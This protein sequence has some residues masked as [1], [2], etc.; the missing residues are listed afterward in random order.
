MMDY[1]SVSEAM[2]RGGLRLVLS[3]GMPAPWSEAAKAIFDV[4]NLVYLPVEQ[5]V[6]APDG[7]LKQWTGQ[8]SAPTAMYEAERPRTRWDEIL[9]LAERLAPEPSLVPLNEY[10]RA[11][12]F[13]MTNAI[14]GE[15]GLGWN[16][17]LIVMRDRIRN[18]EGQPQQQSVVTKEQ[19]LRLRSRYDD[20]QCSNGK[21]AKRVTAV[22]T[23]LAEQ[24]EESR[25]HGGRYL[26]GNRLSAVDL[27]WTAFSNMMAPLPAETCPMPDSYREV[28]LFANRTFSNALAEC[29][30]EHR[31]F[32][33]H[34][35]FRVPMRF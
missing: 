29:L 10:E 15:D 35:H 18:L 12:M 19:L 11:K 4:K 20:N 3:A 25:G 16:L 2:S 27:Y 23:M 21:A 1:V 8:Q 14:C 7:P 33:L 34:H 28:A 32:V 6:G 13:G 22:L 5:E 24:L 30:I 9:L 17:R 31:N 26:M